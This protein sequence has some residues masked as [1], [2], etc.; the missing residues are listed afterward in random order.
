VHEDPVDAM[1]AQFEETWGLLAP[2]T[3]ERALYRYAPGKWTVKEVVGH[4]TDVERIMSYRALRIARGDATPLPAFDENTYVPAGGFDRRPLAHLLGELRTVR[5]A[6]LDL[7]RSFD[8]AAWV[9]RGTVS[10]HPMSV[11]ALACI[12]PGHERHTVEVLRTR[13]GL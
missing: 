8:A 12:I 1:A 3:Q 11:R 13:Y 5:A 6:S 10:E 2:L 9:R 4:L 7:F